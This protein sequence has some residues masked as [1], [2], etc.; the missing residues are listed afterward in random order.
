[1]KVAS[2]ILSNLGLGNIG[3]IILIVSIFID[4]SPIKIN[5]IKWIFGYLGKWFNNS[6]QKEIAGFKEEVNQKFAQIQNKQLSQRK[7][8]H[9]DNLCK[10][11]GK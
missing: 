4:I 8:R 11:S 1:M 3:L 6:I 10:Y 9:L 2:G 7:G 5:P